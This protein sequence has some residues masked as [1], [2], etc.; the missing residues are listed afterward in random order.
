MENHSHRK[1]TLYNWE[2]VIYTS[3]F[4]SG[5]SMSFPVPVTITAFKIEELEDP[6]SP[7]Y[8]LEHLSEEPIG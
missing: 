8:R 7:R 2:D 4:S 3:L 6:Q 5:L 1:V